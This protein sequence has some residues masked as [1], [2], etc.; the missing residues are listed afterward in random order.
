MHLLVQL[1]SLKI[2]EELA[3]QNSALGLLLDDLYTLG[4]TPTIP[5]LLNYV[6]S[7][8]WLLLLQVLCVDM[9][10]YS[11]IEWGDDWIEMKWIVLNCIG[12]RMNWM[13]LQIMI[14]LKCWSKSKFR[15][16]NWMYFNTPSQMQIQLPTK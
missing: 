13:V 8:Y 5:L 9:V 12:L 7:S 11:W 15:L 6:C 16:Y 14:S 1:N 2:A 4:A 3:L 10:S